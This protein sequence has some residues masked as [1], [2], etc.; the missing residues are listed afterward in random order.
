MIRKDKR[1]TA[2][3]LFGVAV[4]QFLLSVLGW[5]IYGVSFT[6][7]DWLVTFGFVAYA[8]LGVWACWTPVA[9][10]V[11]GLLLYTTFLSV[12]G[13]RDLELLKCGWEFKAPM[14]LM[15]LIAAVAA[16]ATG[17]TEPS[18]DAPPST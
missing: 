13:Y 12:Q 5:S 4:I 6:W 7:H 16:F 15:L 17:Q 8:L 18:I 14:L 3:L 9:P 11:I 10:A 2:A 1:P